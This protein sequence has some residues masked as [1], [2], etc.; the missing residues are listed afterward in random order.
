VSDPDSPSSTRV[1]AELKSDKTR[2]QLFRLGLQI[3]GS[4]ADA[5]DLV[6]DSLEQVIRPEASAGLKWT[7]LTQLTFTMR[8]LWNQQRRAVR[9]EREFADEDVAQG[10]KGISHEP[11]AD[12]ELDRRRTLAVHRKLGAQLIA[13]IRDKHPLAV[14]CYELAAKGIEERAEQA[15]ILGATIEDVDKA[16]DVLRYQ[17]R[18]IREEWEV[19]EALRMKE[20]RMKARRP[21]RGE[22]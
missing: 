21:P 18:R 3:T 16:H 14:Q 6:A 4:A 7:F 10:K 1:V 22:L 17:G 2:S 19:A 8:K 13:E 9:F 11:P 12:E 15:R 5:D 20:L